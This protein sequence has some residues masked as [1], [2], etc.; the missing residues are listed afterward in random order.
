MDGQLEKRRHR[1]HLDHRRDAG[2]GCALS[3]S[4][5]W[6][7]DTAVGGRSFMIHVRHAAT[8]IASELCETI[9]ITHATAARSGVGRTGNVV[10]PTSLAGQFD[11]PYGPLGPLCSRSRSCATPVFR[12]PCERGCQEIVRRTKR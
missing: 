4:P 1:R 2:D 11:Q 7:D 3:G 5:K 10:A 9:L 6:V 8:A 12:R